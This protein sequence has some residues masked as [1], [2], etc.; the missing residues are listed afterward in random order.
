MMGRREAEQ[1]HFFYSFHLDKVAPPALRDGRD[2][3]REAAAAAGLAVDIRPPELPLACP[4]SG[5]QP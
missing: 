2:G 4:E 3:D 1:G 5:L